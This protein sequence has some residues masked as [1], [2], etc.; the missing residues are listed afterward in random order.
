M[1]TPTEQDFTDKA[2]IN[3]CQ[4]RNYILLTND[5]DFSTAELEML[6]ANSYLV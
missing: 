1:L 4:A 2:I 3:L 5:K 6:S